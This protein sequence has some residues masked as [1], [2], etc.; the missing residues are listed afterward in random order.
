MNKLNIIRFLNLEAIHDEV[1]L[2]KDINQTK[3]NNKIMEQ[4][5]PFTL[6]EIKKNI[7][8]Q[9]NKTLDVD[10]HSFNLR[11]YSYNDPYYTFTFILDGSE[12]TY[13]FRRY[14]FEETSE[15]REIIE[16]LFDKLGLQSI[17]LNM[18]LK[19]IKSVYENKK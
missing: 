7:L 2:Y 8:F 10:T 16:N 14:E 4:L 18:L 6:L 13:K 1:I 5:I 9:T 12:I 15:Q 11:S 3:K 19:Y 17:E